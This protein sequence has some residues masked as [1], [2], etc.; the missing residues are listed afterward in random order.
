[1]ERWREVD[2]VRV[3][4]V[5]PAFNEATT[6]RAIVERSLAVA[7]DVIVV[8]DGSVDG[9]SAALDGLP[10]VLLRNP[11]NVGKGLSLWRAMTYAVAHGA[12][13]VV[14]LDGDGQHRPEDV[15][16][17]VRAASAL[18]RA[19]VIGSRMHDR[20][21]M[22]TGRYWGNKAGLFWISWATG[23]PISDA[24][25]G[26]RVYPRTLIEALHARALTAHRFA[27]ETEILIRAAQ[28]EYAIVAE[29]IDAIYLVGARKSHYR[30]VV[31]TLK[32]IGVVARS[33]VRRGFYLKGLVRSLKGR[34]A[35]GIALPD[36]APKDPR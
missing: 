16:R 20:A 9:T 6:I 22:P 7:S 26:F 33:L 15:P 2:G 5:V 10:I 32:I 28:A 30:A 18:E 23:Q 35:N 4:I 19:V 17:L 25:S 12:Q 31:D 3:F 24:Q 14:T 11:V 36:Q 27:F 8:D 1:M 34:S 13:F 29:P 21:N